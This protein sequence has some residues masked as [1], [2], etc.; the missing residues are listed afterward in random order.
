MTNCYDSIQLIGLFTRTADAI[1][2]CQS[3]SKLQLEYCDQWTLRST[4]TRFPQKAMTRTSR[5]GFIN[6]WASVVQDKQRPDSESQ[7]IQTANLSPVHNHIISFTLDNTIVVAKAHPME[8]LADDAYVP[9]G[10][11]VSGSRRFVL[12]AD[13]ALEQEQCRWELL[14]SEQ[15]WR[16]RDW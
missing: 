1:A 8:G 4:L 15:G 14:R 13:R 6:L 10:S 3:S 12:S 5:P 2:Q 9:S 7:P 16:I 11:T